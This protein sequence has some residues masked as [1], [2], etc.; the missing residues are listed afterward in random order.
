MDFKAKNKSTKP[1]IGD[2]QSKVGQG[3]LELLAKKAREAKASSSRPGSKNSISAN[4]EG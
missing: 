1:I 3:V 2:A 4:L